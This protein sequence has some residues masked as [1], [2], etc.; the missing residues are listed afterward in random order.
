MADQLPPQPNTLPQLTEPPVLPTPPVPG[1]RRLSP[2]TA[3]L[4]GL[5]VGAGIVG[6]VWEAESGQFA[7]S[8][9]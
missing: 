1:K 2:L 6:G 4:L 8:L 3:G 7:G 9:G 5:A